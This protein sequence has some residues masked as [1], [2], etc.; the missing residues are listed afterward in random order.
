MK[1]DVTMSKKHCLTFIIFLCTASVYAQPFIDLV[2]FSFSRS[3]PT[4]LFTDDNASFYSKSFS[5]N[6]T[7][8]LKIDSNNIIS[9]NPY[10]DRHLYQLKS[11]GNS[12]R[13]LGIGAPLF[14]IH[15]WKNTAWK[16]SFGFIIRNNNRDDLEDNKKSTQYGGVLLN[17]FGKKESLKLKFGVYVNTEFYGLYVTPLLGIDWRVN[18]KLNV[19]GVLPGSMNV[20]YKLHKVLHAG[21]AF[22]GS[23][24]TYRIED[25]FFYR[26]DDN[27]IKLFA[28][29]YATNQIVLFAEYGHSVLRRVRM[30]KRINGHT[31]YFD[32]D[33]AN[34]YYVRFG[35]AYRLRLDKK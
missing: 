10:V 30:G 33:K 13:Y 19:F 9:I 11:E 14:F 16:T 5:I 28:D 12:T 35:I 4:S 22:R 1:P 18:K 34:G 24:A 29:V 7:L 31:S 27:Y 3:R 21:V 6:S 26:L 8:P 32:D 23:I 15:Q 17:S 2:N 20:E 25:E